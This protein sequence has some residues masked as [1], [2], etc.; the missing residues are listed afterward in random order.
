MNFHRKP[1]S[2]ERDYSDNIEAHVV[3]W[4]KVRRVARA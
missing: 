2:D 1:H 4:V 3:E